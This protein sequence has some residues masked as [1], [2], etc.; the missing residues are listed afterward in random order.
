MAI[1]YSSQIY[2]VICIFEL[3]SYLKDT[4]FI[5]E[6]NSRNSFD[7]KLLFS[8]IYLYINK[9]TTRYTPNTDLCFLTCLIS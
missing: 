8:K 9:F 5:E 2:L 1:R 4:I 6:M 3:S 7:L